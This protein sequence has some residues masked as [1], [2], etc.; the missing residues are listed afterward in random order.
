MPPGGVQSCPVV[1][2][3]AGNGQSGSPLVRKRLGFGSPEERY[4]EA[5]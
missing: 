2:I 4:A 3:W 1:G 5:G